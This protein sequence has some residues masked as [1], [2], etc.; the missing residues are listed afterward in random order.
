MLIPDPMPPF[1]PTPTPRCT[2]PHT[3]VS[4]Q[5]GLTGCLR[6]A[7]MPAD[8]REPRVRL[9]PFT[10][11]N[12]RPSVV[13]RTGDA[14]VKKNLTRI[15]VA[16][17]AAEASMLTSVIYGFFKAITTQGQGHDILLAIVYAVAFMVGS[18]PSAL[19]CFGL[20][21][22]ILRAKGIDGMTAKDDRA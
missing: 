10:D 15:K 4:H 16:L 17:I 20:V 18:L 21:Y 12:K 13:L 11:R 2:I 22:G 3:Q 14:K 1:S 6:R 8:R 5:K 7:M 9:N 19:I